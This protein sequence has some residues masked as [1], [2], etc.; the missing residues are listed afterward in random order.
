MIAAGGEDPFA[1]SRNTMLITRSLYH[2][3]RKLPRVLLDKGS[4]SGRP[5]SGGII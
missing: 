4:Q 5:P 2:K 1:A 3:D